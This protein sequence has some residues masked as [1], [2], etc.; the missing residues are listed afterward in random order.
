VIS[1]DDRIVLRAPTYR[2]CW[3][4]FLVALFSLNFCSW[5]G[6]D[7]I[8]NHIENRNSRR[9]RFYSGSKTVSR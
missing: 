2:L 8:I 6:T 5:L 9:V 3:T 1:V 7:V 4:G